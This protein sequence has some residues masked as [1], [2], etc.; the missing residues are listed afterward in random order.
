MDTKTREETMSYLSQYLQIP[1]VN[2]PGNEEKAAEFLED[3]LKKGHIQT[4]KYSYQS[5]RPNL[6]ARIKGTGEKKPLLLLNHMDVVEADYANP[7]SGE[8]KANYIHGRGALDMKGFG[9]MQL[10]TMLLVKRNNLSLKRDLIFLAVADEEAGGQNGMEYVVN[11]HF[12]EI[13]SEYALCE[14]S[15]G[16]KGIIGDDIVYA[17][18]I[19]DKAPLW[20]KLISKGQ[21]GHGSMPIKDSAINQM[22]R[23]L[24]K[25]R[26]YETEIRLTEESKKFFKKLGSLQKFP[27]SIILKN[28]HKKFFLTLAKKQLTSEKTLNAVL[29]DT[30]SITSL[31]AGNKVNVIPGTCEVTLDCRLLPGRKPLEFVELLK[32]IIDNERIIFEIIKVEESGSSRTDTEFYQTLEEVLQKPLL[33]TL[34]PAFTDL[35]FLRKKGVTSYGLI[36]IVLTKED[37]DMIHGKDEKI[38]IKNLIEG[39]EKTYEIVQK[40]CM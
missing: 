16:I 30:I 23:A 36:P 19:A 9:I 10:M 35:R 11:H 31:I 34:S 29:R 37:L 18:A 12:D 38:S 2:P 33:P 28:V 14:G 7:F 4:K 25:I 22:I 13:N 32:E 27:K 1:T 39:T 40:M 6:I 21:P 3:I 20:I 24:E 26:G 5:S 17:C 15:F 8:I